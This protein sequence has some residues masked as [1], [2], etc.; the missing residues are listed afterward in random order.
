MFDR[1]YVSE[2][3]VGILALVIAVL[4]LIALG[5]G[6]G[7]VAPYDG[8]PKSA[9]IGLSVMTGVFGLAVGVTGFLGG[10]MG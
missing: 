9:I 5:T 10:F 6:A 8:S 7:G 3:A 4:S 2:K 1:L